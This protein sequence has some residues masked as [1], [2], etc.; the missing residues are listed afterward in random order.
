MNG[1]AIHELC[2]QCQLLLQGCE[3][4]KITKEERKGKRIRIQFDMTL[5]VKPQKPMQ[6]LKY[7]IYSGSYLT[8]YSIL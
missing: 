4:F 6:Q 7:F 5:S 2:V 8:F 3:R 1:A